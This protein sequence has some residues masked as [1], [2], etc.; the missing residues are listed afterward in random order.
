MNQ[1]FVYDRESGKLYESIEP[2]WLLKVADSWGDE[3]DMIF[4][5]EEKAWDAAKEFAMDEMCTWSI[6]YGCSM[7]V[8]FDKEK[9]II[10]ISNSH[11]DRICRYIVCEE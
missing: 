5:S 11:D 10:D 9:G 4:P 1:V 2:R 6:T 3:T 7:E 8:K